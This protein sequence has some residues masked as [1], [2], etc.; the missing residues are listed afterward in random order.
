MKQSKKKIYSDRFD[1]SF[2]N[3]PQIKFYALWI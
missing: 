2:I 1:V 3:Y